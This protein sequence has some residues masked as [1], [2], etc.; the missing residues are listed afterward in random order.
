MAL[1]VVA[2]ALRWVWIIVVGSSGCRPRPCQ[3]A[4]CL[5]PLVRV[6]LGDS[7][8][9]VRH[10]HPWHQFAVGSNGLILLF[11]TMWRMRGMHYVVAAAVG[12]QQEWLN[13]VAQPDPSGEGGAGERRARRVCVRSRTY[14]GVAAHAFVAARPRRLRNVTRCYFAVKL[15][16]C[17]DGVSIRWAATR[18]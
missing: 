17:V 14:V 13:P 10:A 3:L 8:G 11:G 2:H 5:S 4:R 6:P 12:Q 16:L 15:D 1:H 7:G 9:L 18:V